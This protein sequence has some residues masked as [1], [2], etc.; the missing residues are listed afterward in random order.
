MNKIWIGSVLNV[1]IVGYILNGY[2][3]ASS[4]GVFTPTLRVMIPSSVDIRV[5]NVNWENSPS[6]TQS[7]EYLV[8]GVRIVVVYM[9]WNASFI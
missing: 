9:T 2:K 7:G 1:W 3:M 4:V 6:Q 5:Q 8:D